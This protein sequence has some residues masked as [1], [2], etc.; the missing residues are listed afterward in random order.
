M[1]Y[2]LSLVL[3]L[4]GGCLSLW[5]GFRGFVCLALCCVDL[6]LTV[7]SFFGDCSLLFVI[8]Y[9]VTCYCLI[10]GCW[11]YLLVGGVT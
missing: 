5:F 1:V 4:Y 8:V 3:L 10:V 9:G 11:G 7:M 2:L 6:V